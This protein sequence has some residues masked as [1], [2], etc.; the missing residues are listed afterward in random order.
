MSQTSKDLPGLEIEVV[1]PTF[2]AKSLSIYKHKS[3]V[4]WLRFLNDYSGY[5]VYIASI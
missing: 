2:C 3:G 1:Y 5:Y 4:N